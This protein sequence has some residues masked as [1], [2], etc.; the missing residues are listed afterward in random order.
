MGDPELST[1]ISNQL[2]DKYGI[3]VQAINYPTVAR[4][5]ER[6]RIAPTPHHTVPMMDRSVPQ[7]SIT[8]DC[9]IPGFDVF[10]IHFG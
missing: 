9:R 3:Y 4:G 1:R 6:L 2:I 8:V 5:E 10:Y 7:H